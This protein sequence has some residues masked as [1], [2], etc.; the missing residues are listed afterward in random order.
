MGSAVAGAPIRDQSKTRAFNRLYANFSDDF[1]KW[2]SGLGRDDRTDVIKAGFHKQ[3]RRLVSRVEENYRLQE[4]VS[5]SRGKSNAW[6]GRG[7]IQE[8]A[9]TKLGGIEKLRNAVRRGAVRVI[10]S[11]GVELFQIPESE[12]EVRE[13]AE[14]EVTGLVDTGSNQQIHDAMKN[15]PLQGPLEVE[16]M[17]VHAC[18]I[19]MLGT[20]WRSI[21]IITRMFEPTEPGPAGVIP[22]SLPLYRIKIGR[23]CI[24][25]A[26]IRSLLLPCPQ[27]S[28]WESVAQDMVCC[29]T[30]LV[31]DPHFSF[32]ICPEAAGMSGPSFLQGDGS[33]GAS[34]LGYVPGMPSSSGGD[35]I[36][37]G[38]QQLACPGLADEDPDDDLD[39]QQHEQLTAAVRQCEVAMKVGFSLVDSCRNAS[40]QML[41]EQLGSFKAKLRSLNGLLTTARNVANFRSLEGPWADA[42]DVELEHL[43]DS[44]SQVEL[45]IKMIKGLLS[46]LKTPGR[47]KV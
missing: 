26:A 14:Q 29:M 37:G 36:F 46:S 42:F 1:K 45:N 17:H 28:F 41:K 3:G 38:E 40:N 12:V 30:K 15:V 4:K 31:G 21:F 11:G 25:P 43:H 33:M 18:M 19:I 13:T 9:E 24:E 22:S 44:C 32:C 34:S 23:T 10:R 47:G 6:K 7:C 2:Y 35:S 8:V 16:I 39:D 20:K 5:R 27:T